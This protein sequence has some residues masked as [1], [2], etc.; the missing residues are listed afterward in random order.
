MRIGSLQ[1]AGWLVAAACAGGLAGC[2]GGAKAGGVLA[3]LQ[4]EDPSVRIAACVRAAD[5]ADKLALPLLVERLEDTCEDVR[6]SAIMA[7]K[8]MTGQT[9]GYTWYGDEQARAPAVRRWREWLKSTRPDRT[10]D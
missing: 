4:S 6:F 3:A 9:L 7:L 10:G 5:A 1:T 2:D 8:K